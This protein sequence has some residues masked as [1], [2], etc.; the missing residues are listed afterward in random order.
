V[1]GYRPIHRA[2]PGRPFRTI[3]NY[4]IP[5][6]REYLA[7]S[8]LSGIFTVVGLA[9]PLV[10]KQ[11]V[12]AF[13]R[14]E[15]TPALL[16]FFFL[17][18]VGVSFVVGIARYFERRLL[19][20]ASR[21]SEYDLRSDFYAHIQSLSREFFHRRQTGDLMA[22]ATNDLNY[23]RMFIGP[24]IMGAMDMLQLP[25]TLAV[26][27]YLSPRLTLLALIPLPFV[28]VLVYV[29]IT[30]MHRQTQ[31]VQD[32]YGVVTSKVQEN[33]AGARVVQA[34]GIDDREERAFRRESERYMREN[35]RLSSVIALAFPL[36]G[37]VV[38][39][40]VLLVIWRGGVMVIEG[41]LGLDNL[42]AFVIALV[43]LV[44][45]LAQLG[46]IMT[47]Y[48]R[49][50]A[51]MTRINEIFAEEPAVRD[52]A[53]TCEDLNVT[54][55]AVAF[56]GAGFRYAGGPPV[57]EDIHFE[58]P[59]GATV[60]IVGPTGSGKSTLVSLLAREYDVTAGAV[61]VDGADLRHIPL[62]ALRAAIGYVPQDVFLFSD[63]IRNNIAFGRPDATE[64][65]L[66]RACERAQL[67]ET[68]RELPQGYETMLGERGINLSGG[69]KQRVALARV[70]LMEP[71][72]LVL[73]DALS[74]VDTQTEARI[75]HHLR[76]FMRA[77]TSV[78][79]SHRISAV[80]DAD[81]IVVLDGGRVVQRGSHAALLAEGGLYRRLYERQLLEQELEQT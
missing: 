9:M 18:L 11:V 48:Q 14:G 74:S 37:L 34:Y 42:T 28:S 5:Y 40:M 73:D 25:L 16:R 72:I 23:V 47:L 17:T 19:I 68:I 71:A 21:K 33:L 59:A 6:W 61:R 67:T 51:G 50:A 66:E 41:R 46:W 54:A 4:N 60:A 75:L 7:G 70:L 36:V 43:M 39:F 8:V 12:G 76:Q 30:Y 58:I 26:M 35:M 38:A 13:E 3:I 1:D 77:R 64:A 20:R 45:P 63:T 55:G 24:G 79:I 27:A 31:R 2:A 22:R 56:D 81:F 32:Q 78:I 65:E 80:Q 49:G 29:F 62:R 44:W 52:T 15:M 69:Q 53:G 10:L 57:L